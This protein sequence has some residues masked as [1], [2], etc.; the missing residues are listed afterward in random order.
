MNAE[1]DEFGKLQNSRQKD[2]LSDSQA[3]CASQ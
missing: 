2:L 1:K 3:L